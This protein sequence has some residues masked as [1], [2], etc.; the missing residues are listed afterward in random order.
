MS[1]TDHEAEESLLVLFRRMQRLHPYLGG[2]EGDLHPALPA[3]VWRVI[4]TTPRAR[5]FEINES[6]D[7]LQRCFHSKDKRYDALSI[8]AMQ[9]VPVSD[10]HLI[11]REYP[12]GDDRASLEYLGLIRTVAESSNSWIACVAPDGSWVTSGTAVDGVLIPLP[13][14]FKRVPLSE[15]GQRLPPLPPDETD[16][17]SANMTANISRMVWK[18]KDALEI[19]KDVDGKLCSRCGSSPTPTELHGAK[20]ATRCAVCRITY[21]VLP[22]EWELDENAREDYEARRRA[23]EILRERIDR[24]FSSL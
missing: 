14:E 7:I 9:A 15:F 18:S 23:M 21:V 17:D 1:K 2:Y 12:G 24:E 16:D 10:D 13:G 11:V 20:D 6:W 3:I 19:V 22:N 8:S 5:I 4:W